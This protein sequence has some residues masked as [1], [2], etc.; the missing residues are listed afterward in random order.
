M[1]LL[2]PRKLVQFSF[3]FFII[4]VLCIGSVIALH[5]R[6]LIFLLGE[7]G[8]QIIS[9]S[10]I[11]IG[12]FLFLNIIRASKVALILQ[13]LFMVFI[14]TLLALACILQGGFILI[15]YFLFISLFMFYQFSKIMDE[16]KKP[17]YRSSQKWYEGSPRVLP[18]LKAEIF[19]GN[20]KVPCKINRMDQDGAFLCFERKEFIE[21]EFFKNE[22][23]TKKNFRC[24]SLF[25]ADK[26]IELEFLPVS[27]YK[28]PLGLGVIFQKEHLDQNKELGD[29]LELLGG[30]GYVV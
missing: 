15:L 16:I 11:L 23:K 2:Y 4:T 17:H 7:S 5:G 24:I 20:T 28:N 26:K 21:N 27:F 25:F 22:K 18:L 19:L 13:F 6:D 29:L 9:A 14:L 1:L 10:L 3:F 8:Y 12:F 30:A